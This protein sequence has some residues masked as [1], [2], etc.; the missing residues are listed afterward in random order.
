M[1]KILLGSINELSDAM[2]YGSDS[3]KRT[4]IVNLCHICWEHSV[5]NIRRTLDSLKLDICESNILVNSQLSF[6]NPHPA[7]TEHVV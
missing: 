5:Q 1:V 3:M 4:P 6:L 7:F 2:K